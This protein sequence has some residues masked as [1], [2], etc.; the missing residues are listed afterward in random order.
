MADRPPFSA[1]CL[2]FAPPFTPPASLE[3]LDVV[4]S[5][6]I[7]VSTLT[8]ANNG[9]NA[10]SAFGLNGTG[11]RTLTIVPNGL[12]PTA[13]CPGPPNL[14]TDNVNASLGIAVGGTTTFS[15][16]SFHRL[17]INASV[18]G[19]G[20]LIKTGSGELALFTAPTA[21]GSD[22]ILTL[23]GSNSFSGGTTVTTGTLIVAHA[24]ALGN[25]GLA[26][27]TS[28][29]LIHG[30]DALV[31]GPLTGSTAG[32]IASRTGASTLTVNTSA[33]S[34]YAGTLANGGGT[35]AVVKAGSGLLALSDSSAYTGATAV[36]GGGLAIDGSL[37]TT[38][39]SVAAA[40]WLQGTGTTAGSVNV[41]GT[42]APGNG[43]GVLTVGSMVLGASSTT[44]MEISGT[45][46]GTQHDGVNIT[47]TSSGLAYGGVLSLD[48]AALSPNHVKYV[49]FRFT[50]DYTGSFTSVA[51][52]GAYVGTWTN[53][54]GSGTFQFESDDQ[55]LTFSPAT[56][57]LVVVPEPGA[58]GLVAAGLALAGCAARRCGTRWG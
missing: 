16:G 56:G 51:S 57:D 8:F 24:N 23:S 25:G 28:G 46:R 14:I 33:T 32:V 19:T 41:L 45:S 31:N 48:F 52:T 49:L 37:G 12:I 47:G 2:L 29:L 18:T 6:S 54:G 42:L 53:L 21:T 9:T 30:L 40:A 58:L 17:N 10:S 1:P 22:V 35:L 50:G 39:L 43:A 7:T 15:I 20:S 36:N 3:P 5:S 26:V 4:V 34:T 13:P 44:L 27:N 38:P 55:T 11:S